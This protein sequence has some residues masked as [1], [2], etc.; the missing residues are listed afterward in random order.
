M[1]KKFFLSIFVCLVA[2]ALSFFAY[3]RLSQSK[4][5]SNEQLASHEAEEREAPPAAVASSDS[6][7]T[8]KASVDSA[9]TYSPSAA[10]ADRSQPLKER[11]SELKQLA[12]SD[13]STAYD[14]ATSIGSCSGVTQN[15]ERVEALLDQ[16]GRAVGVADAVLDMQDY[17]A[18]L[19]KSDF[20]DALTLLDS[21]ASSGLLEAQ[22]NY[23]HTAGVI[24]ASD[25]YRFDTDRIAAYKRNAI[26]HLNSAARNGSADA[27]ANLSYVYEEGRLTQRNPQMAAELY[28]AYM[29]QSGRSGPQYQARLDQLRALAEGDE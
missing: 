24:L 22:E 5:S 13:L 12:E 19:T 2:I 28:E 10:V 4:I 17:C 20:D 29:A 23:V 3:T 8:S 1:S 27:L 26:S 16:G 6:H 18:G 14:L 25:E 11:L 21:A 15:D 7:V 9:V